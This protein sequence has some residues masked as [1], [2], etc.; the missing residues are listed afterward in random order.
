MIKAIYK[1]NFKT[2]SL[3]SLGAI[4][5][6]NLRATQIYKIRILIA[7]S[8]EST[9]EKLESNTKRLWDK[10]EDSLRATERKLKSNNKKELK[11]NVSV[12]LK[13]KL[14]KL[15]NH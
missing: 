4:S 2:K 1:E 13:A 15:K 7:P 8:S 11:D 3:D 14:K 6:P 9:Q 12:S 5:Y 10:R